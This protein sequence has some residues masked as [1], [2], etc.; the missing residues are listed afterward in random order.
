MSSRSRLSLNFFPLVREVI[1]EEV[2]AEA[3]GAGVEGPAFV[4]AG[5]IVDEAALGY[6][7]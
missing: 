2:F 5:E 3:L 6:S 1:D 7:K 4:D